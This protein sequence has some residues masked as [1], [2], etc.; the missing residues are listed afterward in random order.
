MCQ[1][2]VELGQL[3]GAGREIVEILSVP[4][5]ADEASISF[6]S[7]MASAAFSNNLKRRREDNIFITVAEAAHIT[8]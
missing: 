8:V 5:R 2:V 7:T 3:T 6:V 1:G 4:L